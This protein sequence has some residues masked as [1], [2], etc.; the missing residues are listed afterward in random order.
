MYNIDMVGEGRGAEGN[1]TTKPPEFKKSIL[2]AD[3]YVNIL[4]KFGDR[5]APGGGSDYAPFNDKG[6]RCA[7]FMSDGPGLY[8]H[9]S[10]DDIYH[11][12]P[13]IMADIAKLIY[14]SSYRWADR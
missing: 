5:T 11:V 1:A 8:Y 4:R 2:D 12:N 7:A 13:D 6:I 14:I 9:R 10:A 3:K